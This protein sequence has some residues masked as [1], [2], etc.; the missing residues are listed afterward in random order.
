[1][2]CCFLILLLVGCQERPDLRSA[3]S[4]TTTYTTG[5][6]GKPPWSYHEVKISDPNVVRALTNAFRVKEVRKE[7]LLADP[8][9]VIE[10]HM[11]DGSSQKFGY[12][13]PETLQWFGNHGTVELQDRGFCDLVNKLASQKAGRPIDVVALNPP[14]WK[15][16]VI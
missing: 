9:T 2:R 1:M 16:Q 6:V 10:F 12:F 3:G 5:Q 14:D 15:P 13:H 7:W 8:P 4:V 11:A